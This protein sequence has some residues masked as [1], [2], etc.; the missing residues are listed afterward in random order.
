MQQVTVRNDHKFF[1][2]IGYY[3]SKNC[4]ECNNYVLDTD[5]DNFEKKDTKLEKSSNQNSMYGMGMYGYGQ[6]NMSKYCDKDID[7]NCLP[8]IGKYSVKNNGDNIVVE[9]TNVET[10]TANGF[11]QTNIIIIGQT[12]DIV[13]TFI[14][15]AIQSH[16]DLYRGKQKLNIYIPKIN[17]GMTPADDNESWQVNE[18]YDKDSFTVDNLY[19]Q[20][21]KI[22][23]LFGDLDEFLDKEN[24]KFYEKHD[25]E[26]TRTYLLHSKY[27]VNWNR[28]VNTIASHYDKNVYLLNP[29][30]DNMG[31]HGQIL[32]STMFNKIPK[33]SVILVKELSPMFLRTMPLSRL[34]GML[35]NSGCINII[36]TLNKKSLDSQLFDYRT[37]DCEVEIGTM[38]LDQ[39]CR[40]TASFY[41]ELNDASNQLILQEFADK[42]VKHNVTD[43]MIKSYLIKE[44]VYGG[45]EMLDRVADLLIERIKHT[46]LKKEQL[47]QSQQPH[48]IGNGMCEYDRLLP[49]GQTITCR[50]PVGGDFLN[51]DPYI[52]NVIYEPL[53][54]T[55]DG[56]ETIIEPTGIQT[57]SGK[58]YTLT[59]TID[60]IKN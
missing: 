22:D 48:D 47:Q 2:A 35:H 29:E 8:S 49:S 28:L 38:D 18:K 17:M 53:H 19:L 20:Q 13:K 50:V 37:I 54:G 59:N 42:L 12:L 21:S 30:S 32:S 56:F 6:D 39:I 55:N 46:M 57:L 52:P 31:C 5:V 16:L 15:D 36:C 40:L 51:N 58:D 7:V 44:R 60:D 43:D 1:R 33:G 14:K 45:R 4:D 24:I 10:M 34:Y 9:I 26:H 3:V 25:L 27:M 11:G 23:G 41:K